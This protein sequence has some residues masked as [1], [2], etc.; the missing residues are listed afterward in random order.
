MRTSRLQNLTVALPAACVSGTTRTSGA[1]TQRHSSPSRRKTFTMPP[2]T[3]GT[4]RLAL[5]GQATAAAAAA[6]RLSPAVREALASFQACEPTA[7]SRRF[8]EAFA[9][10]FELFSRQYGYPPE[11]RIDDY[12]PE[13]HS[14]LL[15]SHVKS[16]LGIDA[17]CRSQMDRL[18]NGSWRLTFA[19]LYGIIEHGV[20]QAGVLKAL[21]AAQ[22]D[23]WPLGD[24]LE[25]LWSAAHKRRTARA[26]AIKQDR[27][28]MNVP[29]WKPQDVRLA[30][31]QLEDK[32]VVKVSKQSGKQG[33]TETDHDR[34][35]AA[36]TNGAN[37]DA[38]GGTE[39]GNADT[40]DETEDG[41]ADP[42]DETEDGG[43][44]IYD[45]TED[46]NA[47]AHDRRDATSSDA[48]AATD[49]S[50]DAH[51]ETEGGNADTR[52]SSPDVEQGR[53]DAKDM[54]DQGHASPLD[55]FRFESPPPPPSDSD[56]DYD[57]DGVPSPNDE[58][59]DVSHMLVT[60]RPCPPRP[61][62]LPRA[63][64]ASSLASTLT[65]TSAS[66][67]ASLQPVVPSL[68]IQSGSTSSSTSSSTTTEP[69]LSAVT[70][71]FAESFA[72]TCAESFAA[73]CS[74]PLTTTCPRPFTATT[75]PTI[76]SGTSTAGMAF[77]TPQR[78]LDCIHDLNDTDQPHLSPENLAGL[79]RSFAP[80]N[81]RVIQSV[82]AADDAQHP[83]DPNVNQLQPT[84]HDDDALVILPIVIDQEQD[85]WSLAV[86]RGGAGDRLAQLF[87]APHD[88]HLAA[89]AV[90]RFCRSLPNAPATAAN[91]LL[92]ACLPLPKPSSLAV[93]F[94]ALMRMTILP[95]PRSLCDLTLR[96]LALF[97]LETKRYA[98]PGHARLAPTYPQSPPSVD[99]VLRNRRLFADTTL[100][101]AIADLSKRRET[102]SALVSALRS[103]RT[104]WPAVNPAADLAAARETSRAAQRIQDFMDDGQALL[105]A[106]D[107]LEQEALRNGVV[108]A[109]SLNRDNFAV[110]I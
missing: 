48:H 80:S 32:G 67:S 54:S 51:D 92:I 76:N 99:M 30:C 4:K 81:V 90:S 53:N 55:S 17:Q 20:G 61:R 74:E 13:R 103:L 89:D 7:A 78:I 94:T 23:G 62:L 35:H 43:A 73:T 105:E 106:L 72:A 28:G 3:R 91:E 46:G 95:I 52:S 108:T 77:F 37:S 70:A 87:A 18:L 5:P 75:T 100:P 21:R 107:G 24:F 38:N 82:C 6:L 12:M 47:D 16:D 96:Q 83:L 25:E 102:C 63:D 1:C 27:K 98:E 22:D 42:Y 14:Q 65:S 26:E 56:S 93:F 45:E 66:A 86:I 44:D 84:N 85:R 101:Q 8:T 104:Q 33:S 15:V 9:R 69:D 64:S 39:E 19:Q 57:N 2:T 109:K 40:R 11:A 110:G 36:A 50:A 58:G 49:A 41:S 31:V 34:T 29:L 60:P 88:H 71:T 59:D 79:L 10:L 97:A 68:S